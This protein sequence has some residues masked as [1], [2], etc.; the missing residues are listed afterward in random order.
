L[1]W[2]SGNIGF[3]HIHHVRARIP[4]YRLEEAYKAIPAL[5]EV[6]PVTLWSSRKSLR[7]NLWDEQAGR[8]IGFHE[9]KG[10]V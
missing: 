8:L 10:L 2:I 3:H 7:L 1:Q 5:R 6:E 9:A 4:N